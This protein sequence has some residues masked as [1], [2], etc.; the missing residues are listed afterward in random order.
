[1]VQKGN[2]R[3]S[4]GRDVH[5][6][7]TEHHSADRASYYG[8][9]GGH[10]RLQQLHRHENLSGKLGSS[11]RE[12]F[13]DLRDLHAV[14]AAK[15][16]RTEAVGR[17]VEE[18]R[19]RP[20][21][22]HRGGYAGQQG[23]VALQRL[24]SVQRKHAVPHGGRPPGQRRQHQRRFSGDVQRGRADRLHLHGHL[25]RAQDRVR[26]AAEPEHDA[27]RRDLYRPRGQL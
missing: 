3:I 20:C 26:H 14:R 11:A 2:G 27:G 17:S 16:D 22:Q 18:R 13:A 21:W 25:R 12:L 8:V 5:E 15:L 10:R 1:M 19:H 4:S 6:K 24:L 7:T 23:V 9:R